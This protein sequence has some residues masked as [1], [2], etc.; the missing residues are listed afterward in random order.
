MIVVGNG[1]E[2]DINWLPE[3][4]ATVRKASTL[5]GSPKPEIGEK[6]EA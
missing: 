4:A 3:L 5:S 2:N 1:L 6:A